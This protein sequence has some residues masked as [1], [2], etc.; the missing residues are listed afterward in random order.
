[1]KRP[2][3]TWIC[4]HSMSLGLKRFSIH[5]VTME[6]FKD[7]LNAMTSESP[8]LIFMFILSMYESS[9][10]TVGFGP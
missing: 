9:H 4:L 3:A 7:I 8:A 6:G 2:L 5:E 1:M 10:S